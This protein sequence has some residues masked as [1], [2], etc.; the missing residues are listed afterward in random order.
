MKRSPRA[1]MGVP[2]DLVCA[3]GVRLGAHLWPASQSIRGSVI[4][5]CAT[6]VQALYYHRY[7]A[8]L[9]ESGFE[10]L[11]YD[12]R[13]IG[14]SRPD[15]M[16]TCG[17]RWH[18]W[19][20]LDFEAAIQFLRR[21][22]PGSELMIVGHS[23]GGF[24]PG[25]AP[26]VRHVRRMLT[27]G[28]QYAYWRDYQA[29]RRTALVLR[30]HVFM[31]IITALCGYF[32]G[33][34]LGWLEDLP[35][36]IAYDWAFRRREMEAAHPRAIR[37]TIVEGFKRAT[38]E[39]LAI[40]VSDDEFGTLAAI[41]RALRYYCSAVHSVVYLTPPDLHTDAIGHFGLFHSRYERSFWTRSLLWLRDGTNPCPQNLVGTGLTRGA[42]SRD[43]PGRR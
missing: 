32:P 6:G 35:P 41:E 26:S 5:N 22:N 27:V 7:A 19:G 31:P 2:I 15:N 34:T 12:Y 28:A 14:A 8:Y 9:A 21:R 18:D 42:V 38:T 11:T 3:D 39:I 24:I 40:V 33:T 1:L 37:T 36:G 17:Y 16:R 30:W 25:L 43:A 23:I 13:G 10:T 20:T 29:N 4:I